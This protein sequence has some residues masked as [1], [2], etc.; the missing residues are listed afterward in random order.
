[1]TPPK[2][3]APVEPE[4]VYN[5]ATELTD[6]FVIHWSCHANTIDFKLEVQDPSGY[7]GFGI[8]STSTG[9]MPGSDIA[10]ATRSLDGWE[11]TDRKAQGRFTP[12]LDASDDLMKKTFTESDGSVQIAFSRLRD[13]GKSQQRHTA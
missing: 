7:I 6:G 4:I 13:T 9:G 1:M 3:S 11:L 12:A 10:I 5:D 2:T 8:A